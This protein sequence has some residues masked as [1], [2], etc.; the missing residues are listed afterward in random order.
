V[1]ELVDQMYKI[2]DL[3]LPGSPRD[4]VRDGLRVLIY[5]QRCIYFRSYDDRID[6]IRVVHGKQDIDAVFGQETNE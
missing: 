3:N 4:W 5:K 6:I 1:A 2:A